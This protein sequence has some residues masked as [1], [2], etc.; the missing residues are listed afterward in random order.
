MSLVPLLKG[1]TITDRPLIWHYPHY[2]NQG[3]RPSAIIRERKWK[4]IHY[5]EDGSESLYNLEKDLEEVNDLADEDPARVQ[6]MS[7]KLFTMLNEMNAKYPSKDPQ[8]D[9][10]L[11]EQWIENKRNE[12]MPRLEK[13]RMQMLSEDFKPGNN[14]WGSKATKD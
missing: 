6:E 1:E 14:W 2:G 10:K 11:E 3:G 9:P 4:L 12:L 8:Y 5:F 13:N 7:R